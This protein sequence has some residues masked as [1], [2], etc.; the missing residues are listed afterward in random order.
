MLKA[1]LAIQQ[2]KILHTLLHCRAGVQIFLEASVCVLKDT[3]WQ[4]LKMD[5]HETFVRSYM[6]N[7]FK[8]YFSLAQQMISD[9]SFDTFDSLTAFPTRIIDP[10]SLVPLSP[11][12]LADPCTMFH[13]ICSI[14]ASVI[15]TF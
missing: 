1:A 7:V 11:S 15:S 12:G 9:L 4:D 5:A 2:K 6:N 10:R 3:I 13:K 8:Q 14:Y